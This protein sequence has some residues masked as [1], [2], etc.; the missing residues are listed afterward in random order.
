MLIPSPVFAAAFFE[1]MLEVHVHLL[2]P[3][4]LCRAYMWF[5]FFFCGSVFVDLT[6]NISLSNL[7]SYLSI[8][9]TLPLN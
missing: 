5:P 1:M 4:S 7:D 2:R 8:I 3:V 9:G 6:F